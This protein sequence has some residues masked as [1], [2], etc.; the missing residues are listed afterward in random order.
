MAEKAEAAFEAE[1][2]EEA[3][4]RLLEGTFTLDDFLEQ[5][6]QVKKMGPLGNLMGM[7]PG[8]P[9]EAPRRRDRRPPDRPHRRHHPLDDAG[10]IEASRAAATTSSSRAPASSELSSE[11]FPFSEAAMLRSTI[12][13]QDFG[14]L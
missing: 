9:K 11:S 13:S 12:A 7:M 1:E 14:L 3:A 2:A 10:G 5:M 8:L 4:A 6:Q